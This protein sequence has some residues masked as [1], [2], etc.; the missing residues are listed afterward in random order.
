MYIMVVL[1]FLHRAC[2]RGMTELVAQM[3]LLT[4]SCTEEDQHGF[5]PLQY[6]RLFGKLEVSQMLTEKTFDKPTNGQLF[7]VF[8][9]ILEQNVTIDSRGENS[10]IA[11]RKMGSQQVFILTKKCLVSLTETYVLCRR[12]YSITW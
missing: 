10:L 11:L 12:Q 3:L 2:R 7:G 4:A 9:S 6:A 5:T 8:N 1:D